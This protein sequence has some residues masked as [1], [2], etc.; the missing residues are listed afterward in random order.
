MNTTEEFLSNY[1]LESGNKLEI[2]TFPS[3]ILKKVAEEVTTFDDN[4]KQLC[5]DMLYTMYHAPG[6]GL[7]APQI[8]ESL[9]LFVMDID[10]TREEITRS[11]G[12]RDHELSN[13]NPKVFIN[14][15]I[16]KIEGEILYEEGCLSVP[17]IYEE[18][19]R[20][21]KINVHYQDLDGNKHTIQA[22]GLL[23]VCIQ[24]EN[25]HLDGVLFVERLS[26]LKRNFLTKR[27]LKN[28]RK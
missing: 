14:P 15:I 10:F 23:S 21:E 20:T 6:I 19:K 13:F 8:G 12:T 18:V 5:N 27:Y 2:L 1:K 22:D 25:D 7:A 26:A 17:G 4:L 24:H 3:P 28:R 11:D 9:R 16:E